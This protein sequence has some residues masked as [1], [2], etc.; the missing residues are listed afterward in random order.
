MI[1]IPSFLQDGADL[2]TE[3]GFATGNIWYHGISS[4]LAGKLTD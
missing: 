4:S 1:N 2:L 3:D